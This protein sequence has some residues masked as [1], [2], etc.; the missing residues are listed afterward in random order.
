MAGVCEGHALADLLWFGSEEVGRDTEHQFWQA[1][2]NR[3]PEVKEQMAT[4]IGNVW[5]VISQ[6][7]MSVYRVSA[8]SIN[9]RLNFLVLKHNLM[10]KWP[11]L[12]EVLEQR[13][14]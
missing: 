8:G 11:A 7:F 6:K 5:R 1:R 10:V 9:S 12:R 14:V 4:P 2:R 13:S 3:K